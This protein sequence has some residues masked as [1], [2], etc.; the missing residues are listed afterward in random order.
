MA[1]YDRLLDTLKALGIAYTIHDD[2]VRVTYCHDLPTVV[3]VTI[4]DG[5]G[6]SGLFT[7]FYFDGAGKCL[8]HGVWEG[9]PRA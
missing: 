9:Y 4:G 1:D 8:G 5:V 3:C 6:W 2:P 7:D